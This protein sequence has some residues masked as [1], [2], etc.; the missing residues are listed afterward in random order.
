MHMPH[1]CICMATYN[2]AVFIEKQL[3][4]ILDQSHSNWSLIISDDGSTDNTANLVD[5]F[6]ANNPE[7]NITKRVGPKSGYAHNFL[8]MLCSSDANG[9]YFA[10]ADQ[11]DIWLETHLETALEGLAHTSPNTPALYGSRTTIIDQ[12]DVEIGYSKLFTQAPSFQNALVQNI[13][14]GNTMLLNKAARDLVMSQGWD[15]DIV[16]HDWWVYILVTGSG[17][18]VVYNKT[19]SIFYRNHQ[20]NVIGSNR[21]PRA[22]I[23]RLMAV[24]QNRYADW[25]VKNL[26]ALQKAKPHLTPDNQDLLVGMIEWRKLSGIKSVIGIRRLGLHR[27]SRLETLFL[28]VAGIFNKV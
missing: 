8:S 5:A 11:D 4:S 20:D 25:N 17:G 1:I 22:Y 21:S 23:D 14:G 3:K 2:G 18:N 13:A 10:F 26:N 28:I 24:M 9:E 27:Q 7:R 16:S 6:I 15:V 12:N 19:P